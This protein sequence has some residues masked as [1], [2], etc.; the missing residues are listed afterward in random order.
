MIE[1]SNC[2]RIVFLFSLL[3][4]IRLPSTTVNFLYHIKEVTGRTYISLFTRRIIRDNTIQ[5]STSCMVPRRHHQ[6]PNSHPG[7]G[8]TRLA[9]EQRDYNP[10]TFV[11]SSISA[12]PAAT[13]QNEYGA[14]PGNART[15]RANKTPT[16]RHINDI[17]H[18]IN[19]GG[20]S[21]SFFISIPPLFFP[22]ISRRSPNGQIPS[23]TNGMMVG[24][25]LLEVYVPPTSQTTVPVTPKN[26]PNHFFRD[27]RTASP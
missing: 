19:L 25:A 13:I 24:F 6:C 21:H 4:L 20:L 18:V 7:S 15:R 2:D 3:P 16:T 1:R 5:F 26:S 27:Q 8:I 23:L 17:H 9:M 14:S 10:R 12:S 11:A 22:R